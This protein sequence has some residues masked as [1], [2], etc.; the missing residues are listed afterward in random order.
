MLSA[1]ACSLLSRAYKWLPIYMKKHSTTSL[2]I[3]ADLW[4]RLLDISKS[5]NNALQCRILTKEM[6]FSERSH[7]SNFPSV[8]ICVTIC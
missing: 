7:V 6:L 1:N 3:L 2:R 8:T 4:Q 5:K